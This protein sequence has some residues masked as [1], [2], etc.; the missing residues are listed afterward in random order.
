M[1]M[2]ENTDLSMVLTR[3]NCQEYEMFLDRKMREIWDAPQV[4]ETIDLSEREPRVVEKVVYRDRRD[5]WTH[6]RLGKLARKL[7]EGCS[8]CGAEPFVWCTYKIGPN[9]GEDTVDLHRMRGM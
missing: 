5:P 8:V 4:A 3:H 1:A 6:E 2:P 9:K 7:C